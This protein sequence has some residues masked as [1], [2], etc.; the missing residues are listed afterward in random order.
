MK[1]DIQEIKKELREIRQ[2][3]RTSNTRDD[4]RDYKK[5][6]RRLIIAN[7]IEGIAIFLLIIGIIMK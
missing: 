2:E 1:D 3:K 7:I 5:Q 4:C 6:N